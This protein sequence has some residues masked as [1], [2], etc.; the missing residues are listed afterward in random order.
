MFWLWV[1]FYNI[2]F[3]I[4]NLQYHF[5]NNI[6]KINKLDLLWM[7]N[8][9][10]LGIYFISGTKFSRTY[11]ECVL[12]GCNLDY[13]GGYWVVTA[14]YLVIPAHYWWLLLVTTHSCSIPLLIWMTGIWFS[15]LEHSKFC[16]KSETGCQKILYYLINWLG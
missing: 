15:H 11:V 10:A 5:S 14:R 9:I 4:S 8:F 1:A 7:L 2:I 12:L 3:T 6:I 16:K 13:F